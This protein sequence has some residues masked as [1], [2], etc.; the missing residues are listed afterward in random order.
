M[1]SLYLAFTGLILSIIFSSSEIAL[2]TSSKLQIK[3][4][5]KQKR[6]GAKLA[7]QILDQREEFLTTIL[8]GTNF[9]NILATSFATVFLIQR[10]WGNLPAVILI[11]AVI[12]L[13][14]EILPKSVTRDHPNFGLLLFTPILLIAHGL[15]YPLS[16]ILL[17][18]GWMKISH[19]LSDAEDRLT[20]ERDDLQH[21][22]NQV[23]DPKM[24]EADQREMILNVFEFGKASV[25][26]ALT[27]RT[28]ISAIPLDST[29]EEALHLFI[30]SG[31]S[32]L[33]V[34]END[35]D[36]IMGVIHI[37]DFF[38]QPQY[39]RDVI[40]PILFVPF[41]KSIMDVLTEFQTA[42]HA[43]AIVLDEHG[44]TMGLVTAEDL[45]EELFGEF[46]DE[47]DAD[48]HKSERLPDGSIISS[49]GMEWEVFNEKYGSIIPP[50]DYETIGGYVVKTLGRIPNKG[51]RVFLPAG[52]VIIRKSTARKIDQLQIYPKE[53]R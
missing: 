23:D 8:F 26:E 34:F 4:W 18:S 12:L 7:Y 14:G 15:F 36:N 19:S 45:F 49:A 5:S 25:S 40:K 28:D 33:P 20:E 24:I 53:N 3:V 43:M 35:I 17:K 39:I 32:K 2:I 30:G 42:R 11:A 16:Y 22:Y 1:I 50:G 51:E 37:Y 48:E 13:F 46:E 44:G 41:S 29:L 27:P 6:R 21:V 47:F 9:A 10:G 52:Q 38:H 31:H